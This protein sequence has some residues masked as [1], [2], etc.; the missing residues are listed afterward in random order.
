MYPNVL[1]SYEMACTTY[2]DANTAALVKGYLNYIISAA[3]SADGRVRGGL[4]AD[5]CG[6]DGQ[7]PARGRRDRLVT[8]GRLVSA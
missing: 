6:A 3:G 2:D 8:G 1:T 5:Q 7:D 4:G